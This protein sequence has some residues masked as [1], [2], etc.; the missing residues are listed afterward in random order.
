[1]ARSLPAAPAASVDRTAVQSETTAPS[2]PHSALRTSLIN[3][4]SVIVG[5]LTALYEDITSQGPA[6]A[7]ICS[8]GAR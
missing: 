3:G 8:N 5:P 4:F 2:K 6:S 7:T 1:M